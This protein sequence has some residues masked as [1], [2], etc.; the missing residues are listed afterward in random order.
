MLT[1]CIAPMFLPGGGRLWKA[2]LVPLP[3]EINPEWVTAPYD[4]EFLYSPY[5]FALDPH[6]IRWNDHEIQIRTRQ[7]LTD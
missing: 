4:M 2:T 3:P 5:V 7:P 6:P 1:A